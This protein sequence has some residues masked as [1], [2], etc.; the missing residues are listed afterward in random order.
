MSP[1]SR[2]AFQSTNT[3]PAFYE[4]S[5]PTKLI[6]HEPILRKN[7]PSRVVSIPIAN[8]IHQRPVAYPPQQSQIYVQPHGNLPNSLQRPM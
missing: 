5:S 6:F 3:A 7:A 2:H 4:P 8:Y 1:L